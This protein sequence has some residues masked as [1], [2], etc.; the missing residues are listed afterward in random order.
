MKTVKFKLLSKESEHDWVIKDLTVGK[1]YDA[2]LLDT[3]EYC[4]DGI[5]TTEPCISCI[6]DVGDDC[7]FWVSVADFEYVS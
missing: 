2:I 3:G 6:D 5:Q 7:S 1:V 4:P